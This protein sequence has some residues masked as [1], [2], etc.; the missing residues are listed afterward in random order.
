MKKLEVR[1]V[2]YNLDFDGEILMYQAKKGVSSVLKLFGYTTTLEIPLNITLGF[3]YQSRWFYRKLVLI[4]YHHRNSVCD[5]TSIKSRKVKL[6]FAPWCKACFPLIEWVID[7]L[8]SSYQKK[9]LGLGTVKTA[10]AEI[11]EKQLTDS[12]LLKLLHGK[13][14]GKLNKSLLKV[15]RQGENIELNSRFLSSSMEVF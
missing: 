2:L 10:A 15:A 1:N 11:A 9:N 12:H 6:Y 4:I 13:M 8:W 3:T 5:D 7:V 14:E